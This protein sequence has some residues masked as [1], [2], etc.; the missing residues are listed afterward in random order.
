MA[1]IYDAIIVPGKLELIGEWL[2]RQAW[3]GSGSVELM[4]S[5]RFDDPAGEVGVEAMI[6]RRGD[7]LLHV[8]VTYRPSP[9]DGAAAALLGTV[10][11]SV[12]GE[13][14]VYDATS[15]P[16]AIGCYARALRGEQDQAVLEIWEGQ[17]LLETREP[18]VQLRLAAGDRR[19]SQ[20]GVEVDAGGTRLRIARVI[21]GS[22]G[23]L[24]ARWDGGEALVAALADDE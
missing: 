20:P 24:V 23:G 19:L 22:G 6:L 2:D 21:D 4:G 17:T 12:L 7:R 16:V 3:A 1:I 8:P 11:H 13:R 14:W 18:D 10:Q 5:Y 15:D 9:L